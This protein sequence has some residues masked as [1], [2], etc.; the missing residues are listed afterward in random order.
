M[1]KKV[2]KETVQTEVKETVVT[3]KKVY[4]MKDMKYEFRGILP[5]RKMDYVL[6]EIVNKE[7]YTKIYDKMSELYNKYPKLLTIKLEKNAQ[8]IYGITIFNITQELKRKWFIPKNIPMIMNEYEYEL[9]YKIFRN[10]FELDF[11]PDNVYTHCE[12]ANIYIDKF[13]ELYFTVVRRNDG[14][15]IFNTLMLKTELINL[16]DEDKAFWM[17]KVYICLEDLDNYLMSI[18]YNEK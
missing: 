8:D 15:S 13:G 5:N 1:A 9:T 16:R 3:T 4:T 2:K 12:I 11:I 10:H 18:N 17:E 7:W 6:H 14:I